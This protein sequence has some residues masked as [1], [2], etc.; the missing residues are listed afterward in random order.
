LA[1]GDTIPAAAERKR[2]GARLSGSMMPVLV[3]LTAALLALALLITQTILAQR[4]ARDRAVNEGDMLIAFQSILRIMLDAETS[5]RGFVLTGEKSYLV[6]Y[7]S[8]KQHLDPVIADLRATA[9]RADDGETASRINWIVDLTD[10]KFAELDRTVMLTRTGM[11]PQ[12]RMIINSDIGKQQMDAIRAAIAGESARKA[13]QRGEAFERAATLERRLVPLIA[14]LG[15]A[16]VALVVAGFRAERSRA[17][18]AAEAEQAAALREANERTQLLARELN[19]RV[20]N[21]FSVILSIVTLSGR[22]QDSSREVVESIRSR[23]HALSRAHATS[24]GA[25]G[26]GGVLIGPVIVTT[27]EPYTDGDGLR[28]RV[29]GPEVYLPMRMVTPI[30]MI[31]HELATN[32]IKYGA[33]SIESGTVE[34]SWNVSNGG[35]AR[36]LTLDW[37]EQGGPVLTFAGDGPASAGFGAQ[38]TGLAAHQLGGSL[39]REWPASGVVVRLQFPLPG[40]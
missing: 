35:G 32:A 29:G 6:P 27:M 12:A 21:L 31:I 40:G 26:G 18:V 37:I 22:K 34:I 7:S 30:G 19:H 8:A 2:W 20:K 4:E 11:Q 25:V 5:Q 1:E 9:A 33:L 17:A 13:R 23:I 28:V 39:T 36:E 3:G 15:G 14:I 16:I 24:Q 10:A 38:M